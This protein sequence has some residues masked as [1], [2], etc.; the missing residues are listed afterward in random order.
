MERQSVLRRVDIADLATF[1]EWGGRSW[2]RMVADGIT[3]LGGPDKLRGKR[4]LDIGT[5]RGGM[6]VWFALQGAEVTGVDLRREHL[7][8]ACKLAE[9]Y[10][11]SDRVSIRH[12]DGDFGSFP[13]GYFDLVFT[14]SVL[15]VA[16]DM[17]R[18]LAQIPGVMAPGGHA[19]FVE[20]GRGPAVLS[21]LR[22]IRHRHWISG[23]RRARFFTAREIAAVQRVLDVT[24]VRWHWMPPIVT[25]VGEKLS[26]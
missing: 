20:N 6:A 23:A 13:D 18:V 14:K 24:Y 1:C 11:V 19:L 25:I 8:E 4:V 22:R 9:Q 2:Q 7:A 26:G 15:V 17:D 10:R 16:P 21:L 12:Y 5:R 3:H